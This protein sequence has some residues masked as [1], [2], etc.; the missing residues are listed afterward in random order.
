MWKNVN[1]MTKEEILMEINDLKHVL[2]LSSKVSVESLL[3]K[4]HDLT[5]LHRQGITLTPNGQFFRVHQQ[6]FL[7]KMMEDMYNDRSAYKKKAIEAKK[8]LQKVLAEIQRRKNN[9]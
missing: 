9:K 3:S 2:E 1:D 6:G 8:E 5:V 4:K 7:A